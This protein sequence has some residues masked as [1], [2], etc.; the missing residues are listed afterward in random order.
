MKY[1]DKYDFAEKTINKIPFVQTMNIK[2]TVSEYS[3]GFTPLKGNVFYGGR[4]I[5]TS[6]MDHLSGIINGLVYAY[7]ELRP[8]KKGK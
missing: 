2:V 4:E 1:K 6:F 3:T 5:T 8:K 7:T